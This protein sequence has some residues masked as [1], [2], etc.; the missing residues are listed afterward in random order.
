MKMIKLLIVAS[1]V[2][3]TNS[4]EKENNDMT[5]VELTMDISYRDN[6]ID[7]L[8]P[9]QENAFTKEQI[10][11]Y[12]YVD[13]ESKLFYQENLDDQKGFNIFK[14]EV[15]SDYYY[16]RITAPNDYDNG[17]ETNPYETITLLKLDD[18]ITDTIKCK[19]EKGENSLVCKQIIYNGNVVW[20]WEDN[21][22]RRFTIQK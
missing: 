7:L 5:V 12:H 13:G 10:E 18:S 3:L 21:T 11:L 2:F 9:E 4:C 22:V 15:I 1:I 6:N 8:D 17:A 16:L 14:E 20:A 19:I